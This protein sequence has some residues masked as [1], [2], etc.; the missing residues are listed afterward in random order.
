MIYIKKYIDHIQNKLK[1]S[2]VYDKIKNAEKHIIPYFGKMK[3]FKITNKDILNWQNKLTEQKY[4]YE[5]KSK[6]RNCLSSIFKFATYYYELPVNPVKNT[7]P[8]VRNEQKKEMLVWSQEEFAKFSCVINNLEHK[9]LFTF[10]YYTGCRKG[11]AFAL[12]WNKLNFNSNTVK[13]NQSITKKTFG[14][15]YELVT[16]KTGESREILLPVKLISLLLELKNSREDLSET[17]FIF[18]H[19]TPV[20]ETTITRYFNKYIEASNVKK[21][22]IHCLRHSHASLLI[23]NGENIVMV[24]KRLGHASIEQ[25]LNTYSHLMPNDEFNMINKLNNLI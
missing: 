21:I 17:D 18:G 25:T 14:K 15:A 13:I 8:F 5:F 16:T 23:S 9:T 24:A 12:T 11:E 10:L 7:E 22:H 19:K 6:L 4:S 1:V 20:S 3:I 2:S